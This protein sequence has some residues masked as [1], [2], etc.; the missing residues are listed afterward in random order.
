MAKARGL[1]R[2]GSRESARRGKMFTIFERWIIMDI[3]KS[4][5]ETLIKI[6]EG[7][8]KW[9]VGTKGGERANL[10]GAYLS[11]ANL[12]RADLSRADLSGAYLRGADLRGADMD[13]TTLSLSCKGLDWTIDKRLFCQISYHLCSMAIDDAECQAARGSLLKLANEFHRVNECGTLRKEISWIRGSVRG[14]FPPRD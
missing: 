6:L 13:Y 14:S 9:I 2:L 11:G 4:D 12:S 7:H 5:K 10:S 1:I 8:K 3:I